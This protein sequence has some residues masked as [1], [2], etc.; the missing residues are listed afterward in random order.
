MEYVI[1][2]QN[3]IKA[4][5]AQ[6]YGSKT[7]C[8]PQRK[9]FY[10]FSSFSSKVINSINLGKLENDLCEQMKTTLL[11]YICLPKIEEHYLILGN[12]NVVNL[13]NPGNRHKIQIA[14]DY[15]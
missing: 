4:E 15:Q 12:L 9:L 1:G 14:E 10:Y 5:R 11:A 3:K 7:I 6:L 13:N 2:P 8:C